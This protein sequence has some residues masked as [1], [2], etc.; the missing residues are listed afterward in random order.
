MR[1]TRARNRPPVRRGRR[2][3][4]DIAISRRVVERL[5]E[6]VP[7]IKA[8]LGECLEVLCRGRRRH[9][10]RQGGGVRR[11]NEVRRQ[12]AL[13]A[14]ARYTEGAILVVAL[15]I[16]EGI[17]R[18]RNAPGHAALPAVLDLAAHARAAA[19][20][21]QCAGEAAHEQ[22]RHQVLE[23]RAAPRHQRGASIDVGHQPT[24]VEPVV[25]RDV[26]LGNRHEAGEPCLR[27]E[28]VVEGAI[29]PSRTAGILQAVPDRE[30]PAPAIVEKV[31]AHAVRHCRHARRQRPDGCGR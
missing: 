30:N 24:E 17:R 15:S 19:L 26:T 21:E 25:L 18:F 9:E 28:E 4:F 16:D 8:G 20:I 22:L 5:V 31:E 3:R 10:A 2:V 29:E 12:A 6:P 23:H 27:G 14:N 1:S 11:D 7:S 13:Q